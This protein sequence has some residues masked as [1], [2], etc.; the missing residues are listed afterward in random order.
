MPV[1]VVDF[2]NRKERWTCEQK[3]G[4]GKHRVTLTNTLWLGSVS[5]SKAVR[6]EARGM[7]IEA[8]LRE[9]MSLD[10]VM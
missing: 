7:Y 3:W 4:A 1:E 9:L 6:D 10:I 2:V 5:R 8:R